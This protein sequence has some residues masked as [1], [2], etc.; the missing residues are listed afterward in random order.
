MPILNAS[1][2]DITSLT[3]EELT[4]AVANQFFSREDLAYGDMSRLGDVGHAAEQPKPG[5]Y[6]FIGKL[7]AQFENSKN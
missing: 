3:D 4:L 6:A 1:E 5:K 7:I 2:F